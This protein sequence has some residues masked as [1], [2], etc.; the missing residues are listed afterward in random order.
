VHHGFVAFF[1]GLWDD[2]PAAVL[3]LGDNLDTIRKN[4]EAVTDVSK[5]L[6]PRLGYHQRFTVRA[7]CQSPESFR[8]DIRNEYSG[9]K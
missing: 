5:Q 1:F 3:L 6:R 2:I 7:I 9:S 4:T 8:S